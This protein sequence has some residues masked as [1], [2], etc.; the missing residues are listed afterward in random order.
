MF[1]IYNAT[2]HTIN[3][4]S[5]GDCE[6][7]PSQRKLVADNPIPVLTIP[8]SG[9]KSVFFE[10]IYTGS[11]G[12]NVIPTFKKKIISLEELPPGYDIYIVSALY[13]VAY[14]AKGGDLNIFT[15][16]DPV[17]TLDCKTIIGCIGIME[18]DLE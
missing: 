14:K 4:I 16:A 2:P 18:P 13:A 8:S 15:V 9:V 7:I 11:V 17:Y 12:D 1:K 3:I 5:R 10:T 6:S